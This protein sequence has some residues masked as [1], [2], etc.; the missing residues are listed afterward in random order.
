MRWE[1]GF[2]VRDE[3]ALRSVGLGESEIVRMRLY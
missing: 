3:D 1:T 2:T